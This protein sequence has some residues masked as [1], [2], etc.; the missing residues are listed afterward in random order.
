MI[1]EQANLQAQKLT[2]EY[3]KNQKATTKPVESDPKPSEDPSEKVFIVYKFIQT[4]I[5]AIIA[6]M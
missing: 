3:L 4:P 6:G 5:D 1:E 2:L